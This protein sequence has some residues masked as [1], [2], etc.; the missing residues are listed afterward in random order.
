MK[1]LF[2]AAGR[3]LPVLTSPPGTWP[4]PRGPGPKLIQHLTWLQA[5]KFGPQGI[6]LT[7]IRAHSCLVRFPTL[8]SEPTFDPG[9][10]ARVQTRLS[11]ICDEG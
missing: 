6:C 7:G 10:R 4:N 9:H 11:P 5:S 1:K 8:Q 2:W 3:G